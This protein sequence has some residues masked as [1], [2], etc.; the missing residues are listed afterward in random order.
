MYNSTVSFYSTYMAII[1]REGS[2]S[3]IV[4]EDNKHV[5]VFRVDMTGFDNPVILHESY[6]TE[7]IRSRFSEMVTYLL[8]CTADRKYFQTDTTPVYVRNRYITDEM[9]KEI[10]E[11]VKYNIDQLVKAG[12]MQ[13]VD[14]NE[15]GADEV[16]TQ[17]G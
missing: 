13:V 6:Y 11:C 16:P 5:I 15:T 7:N 17:E 1:R 14:V 10:V 2:G 4:L 3:C 8:S 12:V 9:H